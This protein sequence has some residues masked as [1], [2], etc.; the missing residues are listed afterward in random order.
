MRYYTELQDFAEGINK[1]AKIY[2]KEKHMPVILEVDGVK[3]PF[4]IHFETNIN[5]V[6]SIVFTGVS[7][8]IKYITQENRK[9]QIENYE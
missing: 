2:E 5:G 8:S 6:N 3:A 4:G 9:K 7:S 1:L